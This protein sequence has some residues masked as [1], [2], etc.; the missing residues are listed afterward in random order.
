MGIHGRR[1]IATRKR[2]DAS[3]TLMTLIKNCAAC[4]Q[5]N[6]GYAKVVLP[7]QHVLHNSAVRGSVAVGMKYSPKSP[8]ANAY[9]L[10][11]VDKFSLYVVA[12]APPTMA[13]HS[14]STTLMN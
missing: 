9:L 14:V 13:P 2:F 12:F 8:P 6:P 1:S 3:H 5:Y 4:C 11:C 10:V 7:M